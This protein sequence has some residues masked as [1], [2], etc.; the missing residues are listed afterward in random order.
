[1]IGTNTKGL[2]SNTVVLSK[3]WKERIISGKKGI[4]IE[5]KVKSA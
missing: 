2:D 1:M 3:N 4:K 5:N